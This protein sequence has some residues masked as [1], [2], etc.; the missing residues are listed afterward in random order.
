MVNYKIYKIGV[1]GYDEFNYYGFTKQN[2]IKDVISGLKSRYKR[3]KNNKDNWIDTFYLF[4]LPN[5]SYIELIEDVEIN[6]DF[7]VKSKLFELI[8]KNNCI[9]KLKNDE[10][11]LLVNKYNITD[12][13]DNKNTINND[14]NIDDKLKKQKERELELEKEREL[15]LE[16]ERE[17]ELEK[18]RELELE[19][20]KDKLKKE[21]Q[22]KLLEIKKQKENELA[23]KKKK[24][25]Q[26][27]LLEIKKKKEEEQ[28][29]IQIQKQKEKQEQERLKEQEQQQKKLIYEENLKLKQQRHREFQLNLL[30]QQN[31]DTQQ[32]NLIEKYIEAKTEHNEFKNELEY[33]KK[34]DYVDGYSKV[35]ELYLNKEQ[36]KRE[37]DLK[38]FME[39]NDIHKVIK[40]KNDIDKIND[41]II[42]LD[43][44]KDIA[45]SSLNKLVKPK[46]EL[47]KHF[48]MTNENNE[49]NYDISNKKTLSNHKV[50]KNKNEKHRYTF[51]VI[52]S[53]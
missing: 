34:A 52:K 30:K 53:V 9:N 50:K 23:L 51:K 1:F 25:Q 18:E 4:Q 12:D 41:E 27:K 44:E 22:D 40:N 37:D 43:T 20:E 17:L 2:K 39:N 14:N 31:K 45:I 48:K 38:A 36:Q 8:N 35:K 28:L 10:L 6:N 3:F 16:K 46:K 29:Q 42:E 13:N 32:N 26:D 11:M 24:E 7:I 15:E 19:K 49:W 21:Q 5:K 33:K 47:V